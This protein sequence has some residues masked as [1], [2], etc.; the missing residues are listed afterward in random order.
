[1]LR[2]IYTSASGMMARMTQLNTIANN[3]ANVNTSGYKGDK[4]IFKSFPEKLIRRLNDE[5]ARSLF[6][7]KIVDPRPKVGIL[8]TGVE[9]NEI[10]TDFEMGP[11]QTTGKNTDLAIHGRG[12]FAV[13]TPYGVR[14]TRFGAFTIDSE[15]YLAMPSGHRLLDESGNPIMV[16]PYSKFN[17]NEKGE[18]YV[19][20]ENSKNPIFAGKIAVYDFENLRGL[21]KVGSNLYQETEWSG[22]AQLVENP[23]ILQ[24]YL[25]MSNVNPV[26]EM[27]K[28]IEVQRD[29]EASQRA[30][31]GHDE[32]LN[33]VI[34]Q[35][36]R[37]R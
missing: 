36:A 15:G 8:G 32:T 17:V 37:T 6:R 27:V 29:F 33:Q 14:Y 35:V 22:Q 16:G 1:M 25:E 5:L 21:K 19:F 3:L 4:T 34:N 11:I 20:A 18:V 2:G 24:G 31:K 10:F 9:V 7:N 28:M 13:Q 12:F 26:V 23:R 30:I